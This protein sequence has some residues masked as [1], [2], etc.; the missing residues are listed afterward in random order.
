[1]AAKG[2]PVPEF[3]TDDDRTHYLVRLPVHPNADWQEL[4][5]PAEAPVSKAV[6]KILRYL[7]NHG[8]TG[9]AE[10]LEHLELKSKRR[11]REN[12]L[13]PTIDQG[14][15]EW[16]EPDSPNSPTQKYR[17]TAKGQTLLKKL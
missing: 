1:M 10:L 6:P 15:I 8:A 13:N 4:A 12:H 3:E 16:T 11:L 5:A 9:I 2:S 7:N 14:Y 17:L